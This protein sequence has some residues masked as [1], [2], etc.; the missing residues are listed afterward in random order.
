[1]AD[2]HFTNVRIFDGGGDA[3]FTGDVLVSGN[4]IARVVRTTYGERVP[5]VA[6]ATVIDGAGAFLMPGMVEAHTHFSWNDQPSLDSIQRMPPE[7]H[8]LWCAEV[9]RKYLDMGWTSCVG[10]ATAKP[11]LDVVIRNAI[12]DGT[13]VGPR[14]IAASQE[15]TVPGGLGDTTAPHLPQHEFAFGAIVSGAEEMR[16]CVRMFA[17]YGVDQIKINLSG[18]SITGMPS[19]MSQF[20]EEEIATCVDE[21][22]RWGKRVAAHARST[23][24]IKQCIKQGIEVIYHASFIDEEGLDLLEAH[25]FD[26][27][28][29]PGLAWLINTCH[30]ASAWGLT[31]EV[32][33]RMG[34]HRELEAAIESMKAMRR[35]GIRVLPG[36]DYGFAWT[37]HGTNAKDLETFVKVIGMSPMEALLS[38]TAWGAPMMRLGKVLGYIREGYLADILLIDGDPLA[39]ITVLQDRKRIL[40]VMKDGEFHRAPP[41]QRPGGARPPGGAPVTRW[42]T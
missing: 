35:R 36:G 34:Y 42:A 11:R 38:A 14:Y 39:D 12:N 2:V 29:A 28:V 4:K 27:F 32:T 22:R 18:E 5:P 25:K 16:R 21:A 10:A 24:S 40:A 41:L 23:W 13:I 7:E 1:M 9:A 15:I 33:R 6:G 30:H 26:H 31:P 3:P 17:K 37:P 19:E 8:I 20:T